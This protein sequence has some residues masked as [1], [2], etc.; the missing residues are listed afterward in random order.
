M[1]VYKYINSKAVRE[2]L[3]KLN[4]EFTSLEAAWFVWK[5]RGPV[6]K[7]LAAWQQIIDEMPDQ[8]VKAGHYFA[9]CPS[10]NVFLRDTITVYKRCVEGFFDNADAYYTYD[11]IT[12]DG[13]LYHSDTISYSSCPIKDNKTAGSGVL[14]GLD[15]V[16]TAYFVVYKCL[17]DKEGQSINATFDRNLNMIALEY[18]LEEWNRLED[19]FSSQFFY[20]PVPFRKGDIIYQINDRYNVPMVYIDCK[21]DHIKDM[22]EYLHSSRRDNSDMSID[23]YKVNMLHYEP[24]WDT[25]WDVT[26]F[27]LFDDNKAKRYV[28]PKRG[29]DRN[30]MVYKMILLLSATLTGQLGLELVFKGYDQLKNNDGRSY[31]VDKLFNKADS[32]YVKFKNEEH[33]RGYYYA[34]EIAKKY[35]KA[36][37]VLGE[38]EIGDLDEKK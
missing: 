23:V 27:D 34:K 6:E 8:E 18:D 1:D 11:M 22:N 35:P 14:E 10:L 33:K 30:L 38:T 4:W 2:H 13:S 32:L 37:K 24:Q 12:D 19:M 9:G 15:D 26:D 31:L 21:Y 16:S 36:M 28:N 20:F 3:R 29:A 25:L 17:L 5:W 7:R